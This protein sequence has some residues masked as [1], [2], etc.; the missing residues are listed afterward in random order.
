MAKVI[1]IHSPAGG[2]GKTTLTANLSMMLADKGK[3]VLAVD[4]CTSKGLQ[5]YFNLEANYGI[6]ELLTGASVSDLIGELRPNLSFLPGGDL[7][8]AENLLSKDKLSPYLLLEEKLKPI[9]GNF[10]YILFDTGPTEDSRFFFSILYYADHIITPI[11]TK[12]AGV[13][14]IVNF[15]NLLNGINPRLRKNED[16][17]DLCINQ[18]VPY[19]Y[20]NTNAK[21][22]ALDSLK[23]EFDGALTEPIG[24]STGM[25][26]CFNQGI[27]LADR[28]KDIK[29]PRPNEAHILKVF[30]GIIDNITSE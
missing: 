22:Y 26:E 21:T 11:E 6:P 2:Q 14:K 17:P 8:E 23:K 7:V 28:L 5:I 25:L 10:D 29:N 15:K 3:R 24:D 9:E 18:V 30:H 4:A 13:V 20:S 16:K 19:W 12:T 27:S 1:V